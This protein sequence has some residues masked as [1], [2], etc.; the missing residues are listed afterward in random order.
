MSMKEV[1]VSHLTPENFEAQ[2]E[3]AI[4]RM[5]VDD[6]YDDYY[7]VR[8]YHYWALEHLKELPPNFYMNDDA[9]WNAAIRY[10]WTF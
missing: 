8:R 10:G 6:G 9:I 5:H 1:V 7:T 3:L 2:L 4:S